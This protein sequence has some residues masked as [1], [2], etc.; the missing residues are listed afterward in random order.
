MFQ[1]PYA[2]RVLLHPLKQ[3]KHFT[4]WGLWE[5]V[6]CHSLDWMEW[7][8]FHSVRWGSAETGGGEVPVLAPQK[9]L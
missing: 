1:G 8:T 3:D 2:I 9:F 4:V 5:Q 7:G 6:H